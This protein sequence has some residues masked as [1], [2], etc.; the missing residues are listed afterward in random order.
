MMSAEQKKAYSD[1]QKLSFVLLE[2]NLYLDSHPDNREALE[3]YNRMRERLE[4][5]SAEYQR[6]YGML[7]VANAGGG[8]IKDWNWV[9]TPWP[10]QTEEE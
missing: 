2:T 3:Y 7:T 6:R 4:N 5:M 10:W 8:E 1:I 9:T